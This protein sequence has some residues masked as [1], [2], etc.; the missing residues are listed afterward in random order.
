MAICFNPR[1]TRL[2]L[3]RTGGLLMLMLMFSGCG[4]PATVKLLGDAERAQQALRQTLD[5][6][7][8]GQS[9]ADLAATSPKVI[10]VDEDWKAGY[11]LASYELVGPAQQNGSHWRVFARIKLNGPK[12]SAKPENVCYAVTLGNVTSVLRSDF[13]N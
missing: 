5:A 4:G 12:K 8:T 2:S 3:V 11:S 9:P 10:V 1:T 7:A 6:W 13:L